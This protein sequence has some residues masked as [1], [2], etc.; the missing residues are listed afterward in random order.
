MPFLTRSNS[1]FVRPNTPVIFSVATL[2]MGALFSSAICLANPASVPSKLSLGLGLAGQYIN[3][4]RGSKETQF[5]ALPV[6]YIKYNSKYLKIDRQGARGRLFFN[7]WL[8]FNI[9]ADLALSGDSEDNR[10]RQGM[11]E[12]ETAVQVGPSLDINLSGGDLN[13]GWALRVPLRSVIT[14]SSEGIG[15]IGYTFSPKLTYRFQIRNKWR[16][17]TDVGVLYGSRRFHAYYY[18]VAPIDA[19]L[20]RPEYVADAGF[21]GVFSKATA[22]RSHG[23]WLYGASLRY[24][25]LQGAVFLD[26]PLV[27]TKH[28][29]AFTFVV[30]KTLY[31]R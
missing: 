30:V 15:G 3:D 10:L 12:L 5:E 14:V 6:P 28:H 13:E 21:S 8:E 7:N 9:S 20:A 2:M 19:T 16:L 26:S 22:I 11:P 17:K 24:D 25:N 31:R 18:S 29:W 1:L 27:E 23:D 4:Y